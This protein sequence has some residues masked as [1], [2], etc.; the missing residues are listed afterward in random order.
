M[1]NIKGNSMFFTRAQTAA[2]FCVGVVLTA[3]LVGCASKPEAPVAPVIAPPQ[4][5]PAPP[6]PAQTTF[7]KFQA[8]LDE[9]LSLEYQVEKRVSKLNNKSCYAFI[10]GKLHNQSDKTVGIKSVLD[11]AVIAG[12]KQLYRDISH[13]LADIPAGAN[14]AI[15][16]AVSPLFKDGCPTF[17]KIN[18][19][20]R[21]VVL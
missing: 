1:S 11:I 16:M 21:K 5:Q 7:E 8:T 20:L 17:D 12:G 13:P 18:I 3:F 14:A 10:T 19:S 15:E 9:G 2:L 4:A 6:P